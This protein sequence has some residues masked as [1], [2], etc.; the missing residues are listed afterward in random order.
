[1]KKPFKLLIEG[2]KDNAGDPRIDMETAGSP[3]DI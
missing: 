1:M 3:D 2:K